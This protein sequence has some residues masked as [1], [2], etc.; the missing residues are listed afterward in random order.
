MIFFG[1]G[2][3]CNSVTWDCV[4]PAADA[5]GPW[6]DCIDRYPVQLAPRNLQ[7]HI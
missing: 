5:D 6:V 1:A 2:F 4:K 7:G 3:D